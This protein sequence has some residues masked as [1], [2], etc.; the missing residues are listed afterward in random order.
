MSRKI[1][2]IHFNPFKGTTTW[3]NIPRDTPALC[4]EWIFD[5][6]KKYGRGFEVLFG[7]NYVT[8]T[9]SIKQIRQIDRFEGSADDTNDDT[10]TPDVTTQSPDG[11]ESDEVEH[12]F[13]EDGCC[14]FEKGSK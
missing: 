5:I 9:N 8:K 3:F 1:I 6:E 4:F 10:W 13:E 11:E 14:G 2:L 7:S 12:G